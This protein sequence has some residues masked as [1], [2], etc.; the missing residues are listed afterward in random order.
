[1]CV[2]ARARGEGEGRRN[3]GEAGRDANAKLVSGGDGL[4]EEG[5][6]KTHLIP[7]LEQHLIVLAQRR[8]ED[9]ARHALEAVYPLLPF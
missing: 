2:R 8:A 1:M 7:I 6:R 9:D 5:G 4:M 3:K